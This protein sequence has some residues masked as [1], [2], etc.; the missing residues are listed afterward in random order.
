MFSHIKQCRV[1]VVLLFFLYCLNRKHTFEGRIAPIL[2]GEGQHFH[3]TLQAKARGV[4]VVTDPH[5][6]FEKHEVISDTLN[7]TTSIYRLSVLIS[8]YCLI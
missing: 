2:L 3:F 5:V 8:V 6:C 4:S 1:A 7:S